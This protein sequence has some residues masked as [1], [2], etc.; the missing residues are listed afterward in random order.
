MI[1]KVLLL[2]LVFSHVTLCSM[3]L[4]SS[5]QAD[6]LSTASYPP[7]HSPMRIDPL[8][9]CRDEIINK[10]AAGSTLCVAATCWLHSVMAGSVCACCLC[11]FFSCLK[12]VNALVG[13]SD[14]SID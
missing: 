1:K 10:L 11:S 6:H 8:E 2:S 4:E 7:Q 3:E 13:R 12:G 14:A 9:E 5:L